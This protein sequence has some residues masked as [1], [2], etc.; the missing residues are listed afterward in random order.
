MYTMYSEMGILP[1]S[2]TTNAEVLDEIRKALDALS[3]ANSK[4]QKTFV[5]TLKQDLSNALANSKTTRTKGADTVFGNLKTSVSKGLQATE[6]P[7]EKATVIGCIEKALRTVA[8]EPAPE[9]SSPAQN[10]A[11]IR[12]LED[13]LSAIPIQSARSARSASALPGVDEIEATLKSTQTLPTLNSSQRQTVRETMQALRDSKQASNVTAYASVRNCA[14]F[15]HQLQE[16]VEH[17]SHPSEIQYAYFNLAAGLKLF[18]CK[19]TSCRDKT[20]SVISSVM[21]QSPA[22]LLDNYSDT[23]KAIQ[24]KEGISNT[25][26]VEAFV[27]SRG[28]ELDKVM[29]EKDVTDLNSFIQSHKSNNDGKQ[30]SLQSKKSFVESLQN[31]S[32]SPSIPLR[33]HMS[34]VELQEVFAQLPPDQCIAVDK[35]VNSSAFQQCWMPLEEKLV[36]NKVD[37][38]K[39]F[40]PDLESCVASKTSSTGLITNLVTSLLSG[41]STA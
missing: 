10:E 21:S 27:L 2:R 40:F 24:E 34:A 17:L 22:S 20:L 16:A 8:D 5:E 1:P 32:H 3:S 25:R 11:I 31:R 23:I 18:L 36:A 13:R 19:R 9:T 6:K 28:L 41:K 33:N 15:L 39:P 4:D 7:T 26:S 29:T 14:L 38:S 12:Q 35:L 30:P 37:F